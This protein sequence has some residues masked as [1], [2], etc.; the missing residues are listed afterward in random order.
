MAKKLNTK[1]ALDGVFGGVGAAVG[2]RF[3]GPNIGPAVGT[4]AAAY[5]RGDDWGLHMAGYQIG[6]TFAAQSVVGS[7]PAQG[8]FL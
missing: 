3:L 2:H 5:F 1:A 7:A 6:S 4:A 8:G